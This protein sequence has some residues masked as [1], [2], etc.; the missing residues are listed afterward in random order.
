M[1][2]LIIVES[3]KKAIKINKFLENED[4]TYK[5]TASY[6]HIIDLKKTEMSINF[7]TW[8]GL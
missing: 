4:I 7:D 1:P 6:G 8:E 3:M 2:V 5:C